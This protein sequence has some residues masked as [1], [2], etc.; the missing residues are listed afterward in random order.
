MFVANI[1]SQDITKGI[2]DINITL[3]ICLAILINYFIKLLYIYIF[4]DNNN[5]NN[6]LIIINNN[7]NNDIFMNY[8]FLFISIM[9]VHIIFLDD[10][11]QSIYHSFHFVN[12]LVLEKILYEIISNKYN[13]KKNI[14]KIISV[15]IIN[16]IINI[17][18][19]KYILHNLN[20]KLIEKIILDIL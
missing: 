14:C 3:K 8:I 11:Y 1:I 19:R 18:K 13:I 5:D 10:F 17:Y 16:T 9:Y 7:I 12:E 20:K 6:S 15:I 4:Y 2:I